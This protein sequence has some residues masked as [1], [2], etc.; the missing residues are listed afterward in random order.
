MGWAVASKHDQNIGKLGL[1][2]FFFNQWLQS[3]RRTGDTVDVTM[4]VGGVWATPYIYKWGSRTFR[5]GGAI[6]MANPATIVVTYAYVAGAITSDAIDPDEGLDNYLGF[7]SGGEFGNQPN[8][9][10]GDA[11]DSGYFN[12][13]R[14]FA[15]ILKAKRA[16]KDAKKQRALEAAYIRD[17]WMNQHFDTIRGNWLAMTQEERDAVNAGWQGTASSSDYQGRIYPTN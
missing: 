17:Y 13:V 2:L 10:T 11:N 8:Y 14:N 6:V 4:K 12:V 3:D 1:S 16:A 5:T 9:V 15:N 7:T